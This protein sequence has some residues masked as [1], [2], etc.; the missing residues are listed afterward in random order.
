MIDMGRKR[1]TNDD[2][3]NALLEREINFLRIE[4][5]QG[6]SVPILHECINGHQYKA[7]PNNILAGRH[8]CV[9]CNKLTPVKHNKAKPCKLYLLE[10]EYESNLYYKIGITTQT[11]DQRYK[12]SNVVSKVLWS[13]EYD[14][15]YLAKSYEQLLLHQNIDNLVYID[16][17][18]EGNTE[19]FNKKINPP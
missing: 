9:Q 13:I 16:I 8:G 12:S 6:S 3:D 5:Y 18:R 15:V 11:I 17:L 2:Y 19:I 14:T 7:T 1:K 10:L 4:D